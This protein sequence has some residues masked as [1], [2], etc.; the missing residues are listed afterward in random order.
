MAAKK[1]PFPTKK[2]VAD[3][4]E[5]SD[6][7]VGKREIAR[8]FRISGSDRPK[9]ASLLRE[10]ADR[11]VLRKHG[12]E[13]LTGHDSL[14]TVAILIVDRIA[15]DGE[16]M[17]AP[18]RWESTK[19]PPKIRLA[20][21]R[22][23]V[24][25][26]AAGQRV[27]AR[28]S[29]V[30]GNGYEARVIRKLER[31]A[32]TRIVGTFHGRPGGGGTVTPA[33]KRK[34]REI[35]LSKAAQREARDGDLVTVV[36]QS[37]GHLRP[38]QASIEAVLGRADDPA[39]I[40]RIA[41]AAADIPT[42]FPEA[43][44][45]QASGAEPPTLNGLVDLRPVPL[46]TIDG[47]DARDFDDAVWAETDPDPANPN[48]WHLI[49]AIADVAAYVP[50]DSPLDREA[51]RR[52]NSCYFP[53]RVVPMLPEALSNGLCSLVPGEDRACIAVHLTI[54]RDGQ[55]RHHRFVRALMHSGARLTYEQVQKAADGKTDDLTGP[56]KDR[57][58]G[59]L[60]GAYRCLL[61]ARDK[62]GTLDLEV[63]ERQFELDD[64][65]RVIAIRQRERLDS[66]RLIEEFMI[67]ANVAAARALQDGSIAGLYRVHDAPDR[68]R[69][70]A[71]KDFLQSLGY[72]L[73]LGQVA[74]P[75][76]F[77]QILAKASGKP[78]SETVSAM[79]LRAQS[80]AVYQPDNIGHFGLALPAYVHFTSPIR[81]YA[82]LMVH[83]A[84]IRTLRLGDGATSD[85]ELSQIEAIGDHITMTER[86]AATAERD[87]SDR[88]VAS[89][90]ARQVGQ[91]LT[92]RITSVTRFGL[93]VRLDDSGGDG[94]VPISTLPDDYY[95][96][97]EPSQSLIGR[98]WGRIY[99]LGA[100]VT[101]KL[102]EADPVTGST[103]LKI[104]GDE[105]GDG[106]IP[107]YMPAPKARAGPDRR[108]RRRS[109]AKPGRGKSRSR[110]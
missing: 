24:G 19:R 22:K 7:P 94:L 5:Q 32:V 18:A 45:N 39:M 81:R 78:E 12:G 63:P 43:A 38:R 79:I 67:T 52:G 96:V 53:D 3:F 90:L 98:R 29:P 16:I 56:L 108:R 9:L 40:S 42:E 103:A 85:E 36:L 44:R 17:L 110:H 100:S 87:A 35:P 51:Q 59:P 31:Q 82:D 10:L 97:D 30:A 14:P 25:G 86:R 72:S 20:E 83:R 84:L 50:P 57:I 41:I 58:I 26:L 107:S 105:S 101:V 33:D 48:G 89:Y 74:Q 99:Q 75:R 95:D 37:S 1:T 66:H 88:Y 102:T 8:A 11:G 76:M 46:V 21:D 92:G 61:K 34:D 65:G 93:F 23:A 106:A 62:R 70:I 6:Q 55:L 71:L 64:A 27:L 91:T 68:S 47:S 4:I 60:Y 80:Q 28:L 69:L 77:T 2:Q 49:V 104:V 13:R 54:D 109:R 73:S 15:D